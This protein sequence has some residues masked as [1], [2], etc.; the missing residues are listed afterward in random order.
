MDT[1]VEYLC[2]MTHAQ[3]RH[4]GWLGDDEHGWEVMNWRERINGLQHP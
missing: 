2:E 3:A 1:P 4:L